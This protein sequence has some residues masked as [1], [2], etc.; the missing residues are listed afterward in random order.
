MKELDHAHT[1]KPHERPDGQASSFLLHLYR[2]EQK[3]DVCKGIISCVR[4]DSFNVLFIYLG[5]K[6]LMMKIL[7]YLN[8]KRTNDEDDDATEDV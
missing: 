1:G 2:S 3:T 4:T 8:V 7:I 5:P 6:S